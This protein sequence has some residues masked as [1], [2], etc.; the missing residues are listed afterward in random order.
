[1]RSLTTSSTP[2][3]SRR[4]LSVYWSHVHRRPRS[5]T[6]RTILRITSGIRSTP[7]V[8][9]RKSRL[10]PCSDH[11]RR[12][13]LMSSVKPHHPR[14]RRSSW[15]REQFSSDPAPTCLVKRLCPVLSG[16]IASICNG[17]FVNGVLPPSQKHAI[18]RPRLKKPTLYPDYLNSCRL[19]S[20]LNFLSNTIERVVTIRFNE[21]VEAYNLLP[22]RQFAYR[23]HHSTAV[24]DV[25]NRILRNMDRGGHASFLVLL[26]LS[27]AFDTV[28]HTI[29][30][31]V[32]FG[33]TGIALKWYCSYIDGRTQTFQVGSQLSATFVVHCSVPRDSVLGALKFVAYTEDLPAVIDADYTQLSDEPPITSIAASIS[34]MEDCVDAVQP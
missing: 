22:S 21:H 28:D 34:N 19:I 25:H 12:R 11:M 7:S 15:A 27:S 31:E 16:T 4:R 14:S 33:V 1:M 26:D 30:L 29:F 5:S 23:A 24:I 13:L 18:V 9:L 3:C 32:R 17:S 20:N 10:R 8:T 2:R 6:Q